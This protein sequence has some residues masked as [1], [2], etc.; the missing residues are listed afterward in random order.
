MDGV[1]KLIK[2]TTAPNEIGWPVVTR[3]A[4]E[5]FCRVDSVTRSEYFQAGKAGIAPDF[6]FSINA[7]E[8]DG[9]KEVEY[10]GKRYGIYRTFR[11]G[12]D[13]MELYAEYKSGVTDPEEVAP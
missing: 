7:A 11:D 2:E 3:T 8:Y 6:V 13:F 1:I 12:L 5:T 4:R 10:M 9:E